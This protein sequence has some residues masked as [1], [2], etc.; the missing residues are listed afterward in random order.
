MFS[1][2]P[3][4]ALL[5]AGLAL[6]VAL[7]G[8]AAAQKMLVGT[9]Q[10]KDGTIL[11]KDLKASLIAS[12][13][14][15]PNGSISADKLATGSVTSAKIADGNV[16]PDDLA[17]S[18]VTR[19][20]LANGAI[21]V[22]KLADRSI[23]GRKVADGSLTAKDIGGFAGKVTINLTAR[24]G[25]SCSAGTT[26]KLK[27]LVPGPN[28]VSDAII[29]TPGKGFPEGTTVTARPATTRKFHLSACGLNPPTGPTVFRFVTIDVPD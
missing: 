21:S 14:A 3:S 23:N 10:I 4:P 24:E 6:F 12:L 13:R 16:T 11:A 7:G 19:S 8:P 26:R 9:K 5:V 25:T 29:V 22:D 2:R 20:K 1:R 17:E 18:A 28:L 27:P 15:T